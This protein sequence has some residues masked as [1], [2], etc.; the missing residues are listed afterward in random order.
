MGLLDVIF[1]GTSKA[2]IKAE[3]ASRIRESNKTYDDMID[4]SDDYYNAKISATK[5]WEEKQTQLQKE[6]TDFTVEQIEQEKQQAEKDYIQEQSA[7]YADWQKQ[8]N[9]YGV[10]AEKMA[11]NGMTGTG[12]S[13]SSLV[14]MYNTYQNR[15]AVARAAYDSAVQSFTNAIKEAQLQNSAALAEIYFTSFQ[16]QLELSLQGFQR[17]NGLILEKADKKAQIESIY[18]QRYQDL[19]EQIKEENLFVAGNP[20]ETIT[21]PLGYY[22]LNPDA[23]DVFPDAVDAFEK[24]MKSTFSFDDADIVAAGGLH[25]AGSKNK[26]TMQSVMDLGYGPINAEGLDELIRSGQVEE[27]VGP[28]GVTRFRKTN[29]Y[30]N[31]GGY[32]PGYMTGAAAFK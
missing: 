22:D 8:S 23:V 2:E 21:G 14:S 15:V 1:D 17:K 31:T 24:N 16:Q 13:E 27:Y 3:E 7:A 25:G 18:D 10:N 28:D 29:R 12:F 9:P 4:A 19:L 5:E 11:T 20:D 32:Y 6:Q 30:V 26:S